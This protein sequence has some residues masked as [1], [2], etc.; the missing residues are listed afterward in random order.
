MTQSH[1][2]ILNILASK[3]CSGTSK[4]RQVHCPNV[5]LLTSIFNF[6]PCDPVV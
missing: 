3:L 6:V 1:G 4:Q 5:H 2:T